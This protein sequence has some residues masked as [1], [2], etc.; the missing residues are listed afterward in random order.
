[1]KKEL[2]AA[3]DALRR[4]SSEDRVTDDLRDYLDIVAKLSRDPQET[5]SPEFQGFVR[6]TAPLVEGARVALGQ[7]VSGVERF[8]GQEFYGDEWYGVAERRSKIEFVRTLYHDLLDVDWE[9]FLA[10]DN[11]DHVLK[12]RGNIEGPVAPERIPSGTPLSHWWWW[13]PRDPPAPQAEVL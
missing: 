12:Q 4:A 6:E 5:T 9:S 8:I 11:L 7:Y 13:Y 2:A 1:M 10:I 3:C